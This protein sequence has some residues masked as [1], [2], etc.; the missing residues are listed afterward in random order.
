MTHRPQW[1]YIPASWYS[2]RVRDQ[3]EMVGQS[4]QMHL[5]EEVQTMQTDLARA[6]RQRS[7]KQNGRMN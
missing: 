1:P 4:L 7:K 6:E 5:D 3:L 2:T